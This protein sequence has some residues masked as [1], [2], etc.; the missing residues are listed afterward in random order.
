LDLALPRGTHACHLFSSYADQKQVVLPFIRAGLSSADHCRLTV[1]SRPNDDWLLELLAFGV[2]VQDAIELG[3]LN[4]LQE[5]DLPAEPNPIRRLRRFWKQ[6]TARFAEYEGVRVVR[7]VPWQ[8]DLA[9]GEEELCRLEAASNVLLAESDVRAIC[10]YDLAKHPR[11]VIH[12]ALRTHTVVILDGV[13]HENPF[14]E[15]P[16]I[17]AGEPALYR[18]DADDALVEEMLAQIRRT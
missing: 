5:Q 18:S 6:V 16:G 8:Q 11:T 3:S 13:L 9:A 7:E 1:S 12:N 14:Y 17:L 10:Q 4:V 15:A 2:D